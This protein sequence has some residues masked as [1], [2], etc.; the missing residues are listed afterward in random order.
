M[1]Q[2]K[3]KLFFRWEITFSILDFFS[4]NFFWAK[5]PIFHQNS[6]NTTRTL[7]TLFLA[8]FSWVKLI[9][10][11][12]KWY[13]RVKIF[14]FFDK[15]FCFLKFFSKCEKKNF[16]NF[17]IIFLKFFLKIFFQNFFFKFFKKYFGKFFFSYFLQFIMI[18][19][20]YLHISVNSGLCSE[21]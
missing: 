15:K 10:R 1:K 20:V 18:F 5:I 11:F 3:K 13:L 14:H 2:I 16:Q 12:W 4:K 8:L 19:L 17:S 6:K 9:L 21:T 7:L